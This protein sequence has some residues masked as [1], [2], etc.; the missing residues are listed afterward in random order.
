MFFAAYTEGRGGPGGTSVDNPQRD[1]RRGVMSDEGRGVPIPEQRPVELAS[2][3]PNDWGPDYTAGASVSAS[4][5]PFTTAYDTF[6]TKGKTADFLEVAGGGGGGPGF[7]TLPQP[8]PS[9]LTTPPAPTIEPKVQRALVPG[10]DFPLLVTPGS[11]N[12]PPD[13]YKVPDNFLTRFE[14]RMA[15]GPNQPLIMDLFGSPGAGDHNLPTK[16]LHDWP[17]Y[18]GTTLRN[19]ALEMFTPR[20]DLNTT[21]QAHRAAEQAIFGGPTIA[22]DQQQ[23]QWP[24]IDPATIF[25]GGGGPT[26]GGVTVAGGGGGVPGD[27]TYNIDVG[28]TYIPPAPPLEKSPYENP[29]YPSPPPYVNPPDRPHIPTMDW[30]PYLKQMQGYAP[31]DLDKGQY[32][33]ER[34]LSNLS[35]ALAAGASGSGWSGAG[36][37]IAHMGGAFGTGTANTMDEYLGKEEAIAEER[38]RFGMDMLNLKMR[39]AQ[40]NQQMAGENAN[41]DWQNRTDEYNAQQ[42]FAQRDYEYNVN[43]INSMV[44]VGNRNAANLWEYN[45]KVGQLTAPTLEAKDKDGIVLRK[46]DRDTGNTT[47]EVHRYTDPIGGGLFGSPEMMTYLL[48]AQ[49]FFGDNSPVIKQLKYSSLFNQGTDPSVQFEIKRMMALEA[50]SGG[51]QNL[52]A[53]V[54]NAQELHDQAEKDLQDQG[55]V[56]G[57][58]GYPED[59]AAA[60]ATLAAPQINLGDTQMLVR[61]MQTGNVGATMLLSRILQTHSLT[62]G[63]VPAAGG[64]PR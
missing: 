16:I 23:N 54:P 26:T 3:D 19:R 47:F 57:Q 40:Y 8:T 5:N 28:K 31:R 34:F 9:V 15:P 46:V 14:Q 4:K 38:R 44:E 12:P 64:G 39:M 30:D 61:A 43:K 20:S 56:P 33:H 11:T 2:A 35:R 32:M 63:Q 6:G 25:S 17:D 41:I 53:L 48:N 13:L 59:L 49:K 22:A 50:L 60:I 51:V 10:Q 36:G 18:L 24:V 58:T 52:Q 21:I 29:T 42:N 7:T 37:A 45:N 62:G 55:K 1:T 27:R